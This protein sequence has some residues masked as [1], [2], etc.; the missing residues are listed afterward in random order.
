MII[1]DVSQLGGMIPKNM[2][3]IEQL[4]FK[5]VRIAMYKLV[6]FYST[7]CQPCR[8]MDPIVEKVLSQVDG[9]S[10]EKVNIH[11]QSKYAATFGVTAVPTFVLLNE[12]G[13]EVSRKIG[14]VPAPTFKNWIQD[15]VA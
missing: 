6:D 9:V 2:V 15:N 11:E 4:C 5:H 1:V 10:L 8:M 14:A 7:T 3:Q 12:E 13:V